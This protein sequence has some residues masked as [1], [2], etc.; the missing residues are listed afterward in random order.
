MLGGDEIS[1]AVHSRGRVV[2]DGKIRMIQALFAELRGFGAQPCRVEI[3]EGLVAAGGEHVDAAAL[4]VDQASISQSAEGDAGD[5]VLLCLAG[6]DETTLGG[7]E[8]LKRGEC[9]C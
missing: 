5:P 8:L 7:A 9:F 2:G 1:E 6:R 3:L 4:L